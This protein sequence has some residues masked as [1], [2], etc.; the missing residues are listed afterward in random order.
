MTD[1]EYYQKLTEVLSKMPCT[2]D[3]AKEKYNRSAL[4]NKVIT[5]IA[6]GA[7]PHTLIDQLI[8]IIE[9]VQQ[10]Y[11]HHMEKCATRVEF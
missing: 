7:D 9:T 1:V 5:S 8:T 3:D 10:E 4:F 6:H 2:L 11:A